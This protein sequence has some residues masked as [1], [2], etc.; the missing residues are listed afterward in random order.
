[1]HITRV[2]LSAVKGFE[3]LDFRFEDPRGGGSCAGWTVVTG[4]N[5]SGKTT[6]LKAIALALVG[7]DV[8]RALQPS[9]R[10]WVKQGRPH[11]SIA[12]ELLPHDEDRFEVGRRYESTFWSELRLTPSPTGEGELRP[13]STRRGKKKGPLGGP[14]AEGTGGWFCA[15]YG[16]FRRLY[17][18]SPEAQ[19]LMSGP[20][21]IARFAT[22]FKEDATLGECEIW[23]KHLNHKKLEG[24]DTE[25]R[26]LTRVVELL[27][28]DFLRNQVSVDR[29]DSEGLWLRDASGTVL[30]LA[31]M[32]EGYRAGL[33]MMT[34]LLRHLVG[35]YGPEVLTADGSQK[36]AVSKPGVVLIDEIDAHLHPAWQ[37][38]IGFWLTERFPSIQFIVS[39]HSPLVCQ[40][41]SFMQIY[42]VPPPGSGE[43]PFRLTEKDY[44][45]VVR[46]KPDEILLTPAFGLDQTRSAR[47]VA[48]RRR[49]AALRAKEAV[50]ALSKDELASRQAL[51]PFAAEE[52]DE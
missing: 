49:I 25:S 33:A 10:G 42:H 18:A 21:R 9:L 44:W 27:N 12:V 39:S 47:A 3:D 16:P 45:R 14:W 20:G 15:G 48:A 31:D 43:S 30:H 1:M 41:A 32:S 22:A 28:D 11:A 38:Q 4:E 19:R 35:V 17:G 2:L 46:A 37:R 52:P 13:D 23:L 50:Q 34:D 51:M 24:K 6:L 40:A 36:A 26:V 5:G 29:V 7:P 8:A